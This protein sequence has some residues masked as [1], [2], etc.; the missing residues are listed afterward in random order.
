[1]NKKI[2]VLFFMISVL[3]LAAC[4]PAPLVNA[5][6]QPNLE[7]TQQAA[8]VKAFIPLTGSTE[9]P[10][11]TET[12]TSSPSPTPTQTS[13]LP[14]IPT[15]TSTQTF[16]PVPLPATCN[17]AGFFEDVSFP[18]G[19]FV[20]PGSTFTK[21]WRLQNLGSCS[22]TPSYALVFSSGDLMGAPTVVQLPGN[23]SPGGTI[24]VSVNLVAPSSS[25]TFQGNWLLRDPVGNLFGIG[26]N[27]STSFWVRIVTGTSSALFAVTSIDESVSPTSLSGDCP[28]TFTFFANILTN[29]AGTVTYYWQRSDGS[30]TSENTLTFSNAGN[31]L[32]SDAWTLGSPSASISGWDQ[33]YID[34]PNHQLW[35]P[36]NFSLVCNPGTSTPSHTA[37]VATLTF[38]PTPTSTPTVPTLTFTPTPTPTATVPTATFT[39][40]P[41]PTSTATAPAPTFTPTPSPTSTLAGPTATP[42]PTH[43]PTETGPTA[44]PTPT[45]T[46]TE[47]GPTATPTPTHTPTE[48]G[49]TA[50]HTPT[51]THTSS[52][53]E[54]VP[55]LTPTPT[56]TPTST[57]SH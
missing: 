9:S 40:S 31:Q 41:T 24:D 48:T 6:S 7:N 19:T 15:G 1:M 52:P 51:P 37:T 38:T 55:T 13:T 16:T 27:G 46:P 5:T 21:T 22:W 11:P 29:N 54:P 23:V 25:G 49:P 30:R 33:I 17:L 20:N 56:P 8:T 2:F 50:T 18:D 42:T 14:P 26:A 3:L 32:V 10:T 43:T 45:H 57:E 12:N 35:G 4:F 53:A 44:T 28:A 36:V 34:Q 39:P 47:T